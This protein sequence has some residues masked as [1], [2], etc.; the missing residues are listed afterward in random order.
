MNYFIAM[1]NVLKCEDVDIKAE[2]FRRCFDQSHCTEISI[3]A[4]FISRVC[5]LLPKNLT[6]YFFYKKKPVCSIWVTWPNRLFLSNMSIKNAH[7]HYSR[8]YIFN[9]K[10]WVRNHL[11]LSKDTTFMTSYLA[12]GGT[13]L[14]TLG[15]LQYN[16]YGSNTF[17]SK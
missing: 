15:L 16:F 6:I 5:F 12:V 14:S 13:L 17:G 2:N 11:L 8:N 7:I 9:Q 1:S 10:E 4:I 3:R